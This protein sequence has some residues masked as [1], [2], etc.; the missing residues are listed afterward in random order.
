MKTV[1]F[2]LILIF[3]LTCCTRNNNRSFRPGELWPDKN[4]VAIN[5]HGGGIMFF[6]NKYYWFGQHN[7]EGTEGNNAQVGVHC[8]SSSDLYNWF[9]EGV[10][11]RVENDSSSDIARGCILERPKVIHNKSTG[12]FV[13][14][15]HLEKK[16]HL[17]KDALSGVAV[18]DHIA[19]PYH[20]IRSER[21]EKGFWPVNFTSYDK[22]KKFTRSDLHFTGGD[23]LK[24]PVDSLNILNRDF[25]NGQMSRDMNLFVDDDGKA[26][27]IYASEENSSLHISL[28][29]DDYLGHSGIYARVFPGRFMEAPSIFKHNGKYYFIGSGCTGWNPNSARS[30]VADSIFGPWTESGNPCIGNDSA[31]TFHSQSTC[32]FP[33]AGKKNA[34]I[35]MADRWVPENAIDGRYVWLPVDFEN[36][37]FFLKWRDQWDLGIFDSEK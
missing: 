36:D 33:V 34:F 20:F 26:Y 31:L 10:A 8:Y 6:E 12:K 29:T 7:T 32:V 21:P 14:W 25:E 11:L 35:F 23:D 19:G 1:I 27:H 22:T 2:Y 30:A 9:D 15:F 28:L 4:G 3:P 37:R 24:I 5:A 17:Y 13:M 16:N 18:S